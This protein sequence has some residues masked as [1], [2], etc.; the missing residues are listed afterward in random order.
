MMVAQI[1]TFTK[2]HWITIKKKGKNLILHL[3]SQSIYDLQQSPTGKLFATQFYR[4][5]W[6]KKKKKLVLVER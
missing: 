2:I 3:Y 1:Y 6:K 4:E 5:M